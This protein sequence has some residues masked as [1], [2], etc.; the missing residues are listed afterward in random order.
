MAFDLAVVLSFIC[1]QSPES[2][3]PDEMMDLL[4]RSNIEI[5]R[6]SY[7]ELPTLIHASSILT[8]GDHPKRLILDQWWFEHR[9]FYCQNSHAFNDIPELE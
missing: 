8:G 7:G 3:E 6:V 1:W 9:E 4:R 5:H 2:L